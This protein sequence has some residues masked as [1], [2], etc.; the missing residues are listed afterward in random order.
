MAMMK[1]ATG[2]K[3]LTR[4]HAYKLD[5]DEMSTKTRID[6]WTKNYVPDKMKKSICKF[7]KNLCQNATRMLLDSFKK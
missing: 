2:I 7:V 4:S 3:L 1:R 6:K 5:E